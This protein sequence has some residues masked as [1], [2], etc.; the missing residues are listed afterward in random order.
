MS[1]KSYASKIGLS[2]KI[3]DLRVFLGFANYYRN[4]VPGFS[5]VAEPLNEC[6]RNDVPIMQTEER[7]RA[8]ESIK[9]LLTTA[10]ALGIFRNEGDVV[11]SLGNGILYSLWCFVLR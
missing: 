11:L 10:S 4:F 6:L 9:T 8:F 3:S 7:L 1:P 2:H 5:T